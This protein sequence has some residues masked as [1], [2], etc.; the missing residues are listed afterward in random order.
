MVP[1]SYVVCGDENEPT[2][3]DCFFSVQNASGI[4]DIIDRTLDA[5]ASTSV[6]ESVMA[7]VYFSPRR[8][9]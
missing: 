9:S 1:I 5:T 2:L 7:G 8:V 6:G 3:V 4:P